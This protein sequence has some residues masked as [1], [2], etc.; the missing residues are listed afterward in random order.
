MNIETTK[1]D[2]KN[3]ADEFKDISHRFMQGNLDLLAYSL[4]IHRCF[5]FHL[6][7]VSI[8]SDLN[9]HPYPS[10]RDR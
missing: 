10:G 9:L 2:L 4:D 8:R 5:V 3:N 6:P 7:P 1:K